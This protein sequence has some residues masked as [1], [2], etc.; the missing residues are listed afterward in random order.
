MSKY[1]F[2]PFHIPE[3]LFVELKK[4]GPLLDAAVQVHDLGRRIVADHFH[5][6]PLDS[7][8]KIVAYV[9]FSKG[10]K[11]FQSAMNLCRSGCGSDALSLCASLFENYIDFR[12]IA[13][14][15]VRRSRRYI[16]YE[17]VEK[18]YQLQKV[19][20]HK[21]LPKGRR[22][23]YRGYE[24]TIRPQTI[25]LLKYFKD[26]TRGWSQKSLYQRAKAVGAGLEYQELYW[27]FCGHKHTLPAAIGDLAVGDTELVYG[28]NIKGVYHGALYSAEYFLKLCNHIQQSLHFGMT[29]EVRSN[30]DA[31]MNAA[32]EVQKAC[33]NLCK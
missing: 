8:L 13:A 15:P 19:L 18:Y 1:M 4:L 25:K 7:D 2:P 28:P 6:K 33:P 11:T 23:K 3:S 10:F 21:R 12:Y 16:D 14:A 9:I 22:A 5:E 26:E 29:S 30:W 27:V 17:Q 24:S 31:L 32:A 20:R